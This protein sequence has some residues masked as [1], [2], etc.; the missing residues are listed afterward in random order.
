MVYIWLVLLGLCFGSFIN[1]LTWRVHKQESLSKKDRQKHTE[2]SIIKGRSMCTKCKHELGFFDL[3]PFFSFVVLRGKCRY[4]HKKIDDNPLVE[5]FMPV[6]FVVSYY[7]WPVAVMGKEI[8][9]FALW[10]VILVGLGALFVYDLRWMILPNRVVFPLIAIASAWVPLTYFRDGGNLLQIIL[11]A[12][13]GI[14]ICSGFFWILFQVSGGKWI[15]GGDVKLG[16]ILG[17]LSGGLAGSLLILF[18]ASITG[19]FVSLPLAISS[20]QGGK[21][22]LPFG[23]FLIV[24]LVI[25]RLFGAAIIHWYK[26][27]WPPH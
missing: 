27:N 3:I 23:P 11:D 7:F 6:A 18:T 16:L 24:G 1:A 15:G 9:L 2:Y 12:V 17:L 14:A 22:K 5:L 4:C 13:V 19:T 8:P 20:K 21:Y 26:K 10:L 25:T